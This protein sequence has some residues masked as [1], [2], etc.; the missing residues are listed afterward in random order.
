MKSSV[1]VTIISI[2][3]LGVSYFVGG[4]EVC[5]SLGNQ[6]Q[7]TVLCGTNTSSPVSCDPC[8]EECYEVTAATQF[9]VT[10]WGCRCLNS[11]QNLTLSSCPSSTPFCQVG[12]AKNKICSATAC[13]ND[14][15][16]EDSCRKTCGVS[17]GH[18]VVR[19]PIAACPDDEAM[20]NKLRFILPSSCNSSTCYL[21]TIVFKNYN[22]GH[23][24]TVYTTEVPGISKYEIGK[25]QTDYIGYQN[26]QPLSFMYYTGPNKIIPINV[27]VC[28]TDSIVTPCSTGCP[29]PFTSFTDSNNECYPLFSQLERNAGSTYGAVWSCN[30]FGNSVANNGCPLNQY[31]TYH[32]QGANYTIL[33]RAPTWDKVWG[34]F[35][36]APY[37]N[38]RYDF[39][40]TKIDS[41]GN[42]VIIQAKSS[43][44][45]VTSSSRSNET[46]CSTEDISFCITGVNSTREY[47]Q[48][49]NRHMPWTNYVPFWKDIAVVAYDIVNNRSTQPNSVFSIPAS[50]FSAVGQPAYFGAYGYVQT[51]TMLNWIRT[52]PG[53]VWNGL[54]Y[55]TNAVVNSGYSGPFNYYYNLCP[56]GGCTLDNTYISNDD[57]L[58]ILMRQNNESFRSFPQI[59]GRCADD[60]LCQ[61]YSKQW[62]I[63]VQSS[64]PRLITTDNSYTLDSF[65]STITSNPVLL[66]ITIA[67]MPDYAAGAFSPSVLSG[68]NQTSSVGFIAGVSVSAA[69]IAIGIAIGVFFLVR[70]LRNRKASFSKL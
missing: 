28:S 56:V 12:V 43:F 33:S 68:S 10:Q 38:V 40:T 13:T 70:Y 49:M 67:N 6:G 16:C 48:P 36:P 37:Q 25:F 1:T 15:D 59:R 17:T 19:T 5:S 4:Y 57:D 8:F 35:K 14:T 7:R 61:S 30:V 69:V 53:K 22:I 44:S 23:E 2:V 51:N 24:V 52:Y 65:V 3:L 31:G 11:G 60:S 64:Y 55:W 18:C 66:N 50:Y 39:A 63:D 32:L 34:V 41:A 27:T 42:I 20:S 9:T 54:A 46:V 45:V 21:D 47:S 58:A 62:Q 29:D 26:E